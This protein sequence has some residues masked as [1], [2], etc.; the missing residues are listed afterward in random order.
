MIHSS[1]GTI[2][3]E[4]YPIFPVQEPRKIYEKRRIFHENRT[5]EEAKSH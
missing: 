1:F 4:N 5:C 2:L 3:S